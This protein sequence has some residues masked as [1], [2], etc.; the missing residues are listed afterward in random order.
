MIRPDKDAQIP[1]EIRHAHFI[2]IGGSG[3]S[4]IASMFLERGVRVSGS[5][6]TASDYTRRLEAEGATVYIGHDAAHLAADVDTVV[7]TSALWPDNPELVAARQRGLHV[8][9]RSQALVWLTRGHRVV[10]VAGAHGKTTSTGMIVTGLLEL[11]ASPSFVNGGVVAG[12]G[13]N[14]R[15]GADAE[16]VVEADESDGSF[17]F[18]DTAVALITNLDNDH[19]DAYGTPEAY[20][21]AFAQ[22]AARAHEAVVISGDDPHAAALLTELAAQFAAQPNAPRLVRFGTGAG[23]DVRVQDVVA[24]DGGLRFSIAAGGHTAPVRLTVPGQHNAVNAAGAVAVLLQLGYPL[25]AACA[26]L[27]AFTGTKRRF[28]LQGEVRGVRVYDDYAHHPAE[29]EAALT[30]ARTV[31][32]SGRIIAVHQPHLYS[33]T[34]AMY[35]DFARVYERLADHTIVLAVDGAREDPVPGVTGALV[36]DAFTDPARVEYEAEW[37]DAAEAVARAAHAGDFV[38]TLGCGNVNRIVPQLLAALREGDAS[39]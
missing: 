35:A 16:F 20:T 7:V 23:N 30:A 28:D 8:L 37:A 33:R 24:A 14:Q 1:A 22:F 15:L 27:A 34:A 21:A 31:V 25:A 2:G 12:L 3:M 18:Y 6:R 26:S 13:T 10:A 39:A 36:A 9:H 4:G 5:D 19:L 29:V 11:D 38:I 32:G 17:L